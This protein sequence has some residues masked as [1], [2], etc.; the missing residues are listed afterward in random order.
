MTPLSPSALMQAAGAY[1]QVDRG[2]ASDAASAFGGGGFGAAMERAAQG[3]IDTGRQADTQAAAAISGTGN[4]TEV[5]AAV[6]K[7]ELALQATSAIRDR[8]VQAY[9]DIMRTPI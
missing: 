2:D 7:A 8:M 3:V 9:Q 5:V 4:M 1:A 6:S